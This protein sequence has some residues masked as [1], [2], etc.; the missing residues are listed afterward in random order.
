MS[1]LCPRPYRARWDSRDVCVE[2]SLGLQN[3]SSWHSMF[4]PYLAGGRVQD[5]S[6][7]V[8]IRNSDRKPPAEGRG[9]RRSRVR[10]GS[11]DTESTKTNNPQSTDSQINRFAHRPSPFSQD[12]DSALRA[13]PQGRLQSLNQTRR[14]GR[15]YSPRS[16]IPRLA[17]STARG[18]PIT[19]A[20]RPAALPSRRWLGNRSLRQSVQMPAMWIDSGAK[21]AR[22]RASALACQRSK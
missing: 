11:Q 12:V 8:H 9:H 22:T 7:P 1:G 16:G 4:R 19:A 5:K 14:M 15:R 20:K 21:P 2:T 3:S 10:Y 18:R 6:L 13:R 17:S